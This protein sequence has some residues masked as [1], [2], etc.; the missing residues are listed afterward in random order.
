MPLFSYTGKDQT[1]RAVTGQLEASHIAEAV[2]QVV[3]LNIELHSIGMLDASA[4]GVHIPSK[5]TELSAD[6]VKR[7]DA[8]LANCGG[9]VPVL[10]SAIAE[11]PES[12]SI[13]SCKRLAASLQGGLSADE[14]LNDRWLVSY[15]PL[16]LQSTD[17]KAGDQGK[18][19]VSAANLL[20]S[21]SADTGAR[22]LSFQLFIYP[23]VLIIITLTLLILLLIFIVPVFDRMYQEFGLSLPVPTQFVCSLSQYTIRHPFRLLGL[24]VTVGAVVIGTIAF[25]KQFSLTNFLFGS[26]A[27]GT[28]GNLIAMSRFTAT[29]AELLRIGIDLSDSVSV[30]GR[31]AGHRYFQTLSQRLAKE[32]GPSDNI[33]RDSSYALYFP[34]TVMY[35]L[36][37]PS[38]GESRIQLLRQLSSIYSQRVQH[39]YSFLSSYF[40]PVTIV[41]LGGTIGFVIVALFQPLISLLTSLA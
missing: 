39:R 8:V 3:A 34:S 14:L 35:A 31:V 29:L 1:G 20:R 17:G 33:P 4:A 30:A 10:K 5:S 25:W 22:R 9:L 28:S 2:A 15:L 18:A 41:V 13:S 40:G 6:S 19:D 12:I 7:I 23:V 11:S 32:I 26:L 36:Q 37:L 16:L 38:D 27:A 24:L 21:M